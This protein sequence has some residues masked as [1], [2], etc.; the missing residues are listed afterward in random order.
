MR[1]LSF[2]Q[3]NGSMKLSF[4]I[5]NL[6]LP[7]IQNNW[8]HIYIAQRVNNLTYSLLFT[9]TSFSLFGHLLW[10]N[11]P[12]NFLVYNIL[13]DFDH[14]LVEQTGRFLEFTACLVHKHTLP[15]HIVVNQIQVLA[16]PFKHFPLLFLN[17][18]LNL[19][20]SLFK[21]VAHLLI[22]L[23][24]KLFEQFIRLLR[25]DHPRLP[26]LLFSPQ[27]CSFYLYQRVI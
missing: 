24:K 10:L 4:Y 2:I 6:L 17:S 25:L 5:W 3:E 12:I 1:S 8:I 9:Q 16:V 22:F 11:K 27:H 21:F 26:A 15:I 20:S 13:C 18:T 7:P 14:F 19:L 23:L